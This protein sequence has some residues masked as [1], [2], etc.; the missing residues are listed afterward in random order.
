[1]AFNLLQKLVWIIKDDVHF[2][3][4]QAEWPETNAHLKFDQLA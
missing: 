3:P 4:N 2:D 1:M